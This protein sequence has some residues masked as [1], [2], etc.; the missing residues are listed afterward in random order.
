MNEQYL[1][2]WEWH[3]SL[4][5]EP[6]LASIIPDMVSQVVMTSLSADSGTDA[7]WD[8]LQEEL[9]TLSTLADHLQK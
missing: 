5:K 6:S 8:E 7:Q 2:Y 1:A 4:D 3:K 9:L